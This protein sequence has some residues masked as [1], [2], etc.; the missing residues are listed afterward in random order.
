M[1]HAEG[2]EEV[3]GTQKFSERRIGALTIRIDRTIC[4]GF[5]DCINTAPD[6]FTLDGDGIAEFRPAAET[7]ERERLI[8]ACDACPVDAIV[9]LDADG[10]QLVP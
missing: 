1:A 9:V 3:R 7:V 4:V 6:A 2:L 10:N 8:R 5:G